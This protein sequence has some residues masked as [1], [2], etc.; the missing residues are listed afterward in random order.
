M[1]SDARF[2]GAVA[3]TKGEAVIDEMPC[4]EVWD[5]RC[6]SLPT[7]NG[8]TELAGTDQSPRSRF[9]LPENIAF[10]VVSSTGA[11][12]IQ[13]TPFLLSA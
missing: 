4:R 12:R 7:G 9:A 6:A 2:A 10:R 11:S 5:R 1:G 13:L 8:I 3:D